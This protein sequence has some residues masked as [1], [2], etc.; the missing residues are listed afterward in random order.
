[1]RIKLRYVVPIVQMALAVFFYWQSDLWGR[2][3]I[4]RVHGTFGPSLY[5]LVLIAINAPIA[6]VRGLIYRHVPE[7]FG[8]FIFVALIGLLWYWVGLN[9][10]RW[11]K[12]RTVLNFSQATQRLAV[13]LFLVA[14]GVFLG[15]VPIYGIGLGYGAKWTGA[16]ILGPWF[17]WSLT[18]IFFFGWD[19]V[20]CIRPARQLS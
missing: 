10:E 13:D 1:M 19:V 14:L 16:I 4:Q 17:L 3:M 18:L 8:R 15:L 11:K 5:F 9:V 20:R 12:S 7:M 6:L 2:E